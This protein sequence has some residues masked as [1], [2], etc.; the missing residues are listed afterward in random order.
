MG[1]GVPKV[2]AGEERTRKGAVRSGNMEHPVRGQSQE[3]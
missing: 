2:D 1:R 3:K